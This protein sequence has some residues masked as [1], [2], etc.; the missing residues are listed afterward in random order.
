MC[1]RAE[2]RNR[3]GAIV[4]K[5]NGQTKPPRRK[6]KATIET[7]RALPNAADGSARPW[8]EAGAATPES[9]TTGYESRIDKLAAGAKA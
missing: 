5:R 3:K 9:R 4:G 6:P 2:G 1:A 7:G 8:S